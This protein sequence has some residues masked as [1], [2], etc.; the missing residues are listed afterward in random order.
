MDDADL[1]YVPR[2]MAAMQALQPFWHGTSVELELYVDAW[3]DDQHWTAREARR[4]WLTVHP[5]LRLHMAGHR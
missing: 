5:Q 2:L 3:L 1:T 4:A